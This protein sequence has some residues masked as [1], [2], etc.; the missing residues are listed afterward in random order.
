[1]VNN[2]GFT[3][4]Y[5]HREKENKTVGSKPYSHSSLYHTFREFPFLSPIS[6]RL[7]DDLFSQDVFTKIYTANNDV[8]VRQ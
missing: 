2:L 3:W 7:W 6:S 4:L 1:M 5:S 8:H